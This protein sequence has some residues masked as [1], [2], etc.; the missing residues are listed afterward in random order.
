MIMR[1]PRDPVKSGSRTPYQDTEFIEDLTTVTKFWDAGNHS[2]MQLG[3]T[4]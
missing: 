3:P 4:N 2:E 1:T